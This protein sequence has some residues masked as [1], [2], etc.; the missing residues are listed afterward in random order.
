MLTVGVSPAV[1]PTCCVAVLPPE[2]GGRGQ[3]QDSQPTVGSS[4][5]LPLAAALLRAAPLTHTDLFPGAAVPP[6]LCPHLC[7]P[8]L[9]WE[10]WQ[11]CPQ[12]L[13]PLGCGLLATLTPAQGISL[14]T[15]VLGWKARVQWQERWAGCTA[16]HRSF[17]Q[18]RTWC[19]GWPFCPA[20]WQSWFVP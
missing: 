12:P 11:R 16:S 18:D 4:G 17:S 2:A 6:G 3:L 20:P 14:G 19:S 5:H 10:G 8:S 15:R 1:C 13:T 9:A 7:H